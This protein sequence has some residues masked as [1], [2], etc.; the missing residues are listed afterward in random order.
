LIEIRDEQPG[1]IDAI[2]EVN[3]Q[4]FNQEQEGRIV[5]A[6]REQGGVLLSLV[7]V[8]NGLVVGHVMFSPLTVGPAIGAGLGPMAVL[9]AHQR[10]GI[11]T[12]LV[13]RGLARLKDSGCPFVVVVGHPAFYPRFGFQ[14]AAGYGLTCE[15]DVPADVFMV[16]VLEPELTRNLTGLAKYRPEFSTVE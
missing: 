5:D 7:A 15:F 12:Q 8:S 16:A 2:R 13:E 6:L 1:D 4:A 9:P 14:A 11:G 10:Q 3:R